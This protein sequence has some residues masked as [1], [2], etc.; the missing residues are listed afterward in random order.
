MWNTLQSDRSATTDKV[1]MEA[2]ILLSR[3]EINRALIL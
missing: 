2:E 1:E 3:R